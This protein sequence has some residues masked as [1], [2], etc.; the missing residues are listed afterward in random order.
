MNHFSGWEKFHMRIFL[1]FLAAIM[2]CLFSSPNSRA[3]GH[4]ITKNIENIENILKNSIYSKEFFNEIVCGNKDDVIIHNMKVKIKNSYIKNSMREPHDFDF[5]KIQDKCRRATAKYHIWAFYL[6]ENI[7]KIDDKWMLNLEKSIF[8]SRYVCSQSFFN[9]FSHR[10]AHILM[11]EK[12][13]KIQQVEKAKA[14]Q[15]VSF[16]DKMFRRK[17]L[18]PMMHF[19]IRLVIYYFP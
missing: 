15:S 12:L 4:C 5:S 17:E 3:S 11:N 7:R 9:I 14:D 2:I 13:F 18:I 16:I 19:I 6:E 8:E 10:I 1:N